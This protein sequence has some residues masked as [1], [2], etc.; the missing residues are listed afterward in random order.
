MEL[1][2]E[3]WQ[4]SPSTIDLSSEEI[5]LWCV[6]LDSAGPSPSLVEGHL[7]DDEGARAKRFHFE[8][9]RARFVR[10]RAALRCIL[11]R[12]IRVTPEKI[13]FSYQANGKPELAETDNH[14]GV[15]FNLSHSGEFAI[16]GVGRQRRIGVD[17]ERYRTLEFLDVASRYFSEPEYRELSALPVNELEKNFFA[18]WTRKEAFLKALGEGIGVL[19]PQVSVT[20]AHFEAP[21]LMEF[22]GHPD[23][24]LRWSL[25]DIRVHQDYAAAMAFERGPVKLQHFIFDKYF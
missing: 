24:R 18:C 13:R 7:S 3:H 15:N 11:A 21:K 5:H 16:I 6:H 10:A 20:V 4:T 9:D 17:V 12:Y 25:E 8:R 19:L 14:T 23:A 1:S 2:R 22:Q